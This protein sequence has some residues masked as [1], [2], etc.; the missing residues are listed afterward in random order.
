MEDVLNKLVNN[1]GDA[2]PVFDITYFSDYYTLYIPAPPF[3]E[4]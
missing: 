3:A 4:N 1:L 2:H